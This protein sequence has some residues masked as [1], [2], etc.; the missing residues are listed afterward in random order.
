MARTHLQNI[1]AML[2]R[3]SLEEVR[4]LHQTLH[5]LEELLAAHAIVAGGQALPDDQPVGAVRGYIEHKFIPNKARTRLN[6]PYAYLRL[7]RNGKY[8]S[9][10]LG[11]VEPR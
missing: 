10:Y 3:L 4:D 6:G 11:K 1:E 8:T 7:R 5:D 2:G 9:K